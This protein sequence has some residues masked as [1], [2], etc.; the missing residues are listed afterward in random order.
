M[1]LY[2]N[3][4]RIAPRSEAL[5]DCTF[6]PK[7]RIYG[8]GGAFPIYAQYQNKYCLKESTLQD[9]DRAILGFCDRTCQVESLSI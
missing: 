2:A 6:V 9:S 1:R 3:R 8:V 7:D 5:R 4:E